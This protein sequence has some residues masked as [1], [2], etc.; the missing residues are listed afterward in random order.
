[1]NKTAQLRA[2]GAMAEEWRSLYGN[3]I[4]TAESQLASANIAIYP[5]DLRSLVG[6][7]QTSFSGAHDG[8]IDRAKEQWK[9][10]KR[11]RRRPAAKLA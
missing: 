9:Q 2:A 11:W 3:E 8:D 10:W 7:R 6:G 1:M 4:G 5:V